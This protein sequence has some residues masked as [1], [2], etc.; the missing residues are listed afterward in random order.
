MNKKGFTLIELLIVIAI[1][2][3]LAAIA[4]PMYR[5]EVLRNKIITSALKTMPLC[6][7]VEPFSIKIKGK[8]VVVDGSTQNL[9]TEAKSILNPKIRG[10][11]TDPELTVFLISKPREVPVGQYSVSKEPAHQA[12]VD[13]HVIYYPVNIPAGKVSLLYW[14][15]PAKRL[16]GSKHYKGY[17]SINYFVGMWINQL[18]KDVPLEQSFEV[19]IKN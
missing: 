1:I 9:V 4:I 7:D 19:L 8:C 2:G 5:T 6:N 12:Y 17:E 16:M 13:V 14:D 3:I 11:I 15:P 10:Q 18:A